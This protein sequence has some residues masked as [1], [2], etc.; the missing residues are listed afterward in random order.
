MSAPGG[1]Q[2]GSPPTVSPFH[3]DIDIIDVH[4]AAFWWNAQYGAGALSSA[5]GPVRL[6]PEAAAQ[7]SVDPASKWIGAGISNLTFISE[8]ISDIA[9]NPQVL[10]PAEM[11][12]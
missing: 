2:S 9:G 1:C 8:Q 3:G 11:G 4:R 6:R 7:F 5:L 10:S 12:K